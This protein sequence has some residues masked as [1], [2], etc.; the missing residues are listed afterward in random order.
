MPHMLAA[1][2]GR[3]R[4]LAIPAAAVGLVVAL[5]AVSYGLVT[6]LPAEAYTGPPEASV[7]W[8]TWL[9]ILPDLGRLSIWPGPATPLHPV[10]P[11][12]SWLAPG[13]AAGLVS[14]AFLAACVV[15]AWRSGSVLAVWATSLV[16]GTV[17][18]LAPW[19]RFPSG[20]PEVAGPLYERYLYAAVT[21]PALALAWALQRI[22][23]ERPRAV[24]VLTLA[25][26]VG[27]GA[28]TARRGEAWSADIPLARAGL[29]IAPGS[30]N[31]WAHLGAAHL[32]R[33]QQTGDAAES[34]E[35]LRAIE[36]ALA[37][38]PDL[39]RAAVNRFILLSLLG[40]EDEAE[41]LAVVLQSRWPED[42][43]VLHNVAAWHEGSQRWA[44]A[45]ALFE[46]ALR[47]G[48]AH[49]ETA[50]RLAACREAML[51]APSPGGR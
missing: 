47:T 27:L 17:L 41:R 10:A 22:V 9:S 31:L 50:A 1:G 42:P 5:R 26:L 7:R 8:F 18:M 37:L 51:A 6:E 39:S 13:V 30:A 19:V 49:P 20:F 33:Y 38:D 34:D 2:F 44:Q 36:R 43:F 23:G 4:S 11:A 3:A 14:L 16:L 46:R 24:G 40:R 45:A 25:L 29:A 35:A 12:E 32:D 28:V 21:G 48:R 15:F